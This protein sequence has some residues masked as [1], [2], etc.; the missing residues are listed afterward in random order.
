MAAPGR[1]FGAGGWVKPETVADLVVPQL[2]A[3]VTNT[4][5]LRG[6]QQA[7]HRLK[8]R[9]TGPSKEVVEAGM[10]PT[11][12]PHELFYT[13]MPRGILSAGSRAVW[14]FSL[15][16]VFGP[17]LFVGCATKGVAGGP[18][19]IA[20]GLAEGLVFGVLW[21][22]IGYGATASQ[23]LGGAFFSATSPYWVYGQRR[24]WHPVHREWA[25]P[26]TQ[27]DARLN[28]LPSDGEL[29]EE[30]MARMARRRDAPSGEVH[31]RGRELYAALGINE[32]ATQKEIKHAYLKASMHLHPD[33]NPSPSAKEEFDKVAKA[34]KVLSDPVARKKYDA[35][36]EDALKAG[37]QMDRR[38]TLRSIFGG[39]V[40]RDL[41]G[42]VR[43]SRVSRRLVDAVHYS[44]EESQILTTRAQERAATTL[45]TYLTDHP[46]EM[47]T[48]AAGKAAYERQVKVWENAVRKRF[49]AFVN[50]GVA[51]EMMYVIG[52]EYHEVLDEDAKSAAERVVRG[53][54]A[55]PA[56]AL[57]RVSPWLRIAYRGGK[58]ARDPAYVMETVWSLSAP[59]L[60]ATARYAAVKVILDES[61]DAAELRRRKVAL[62]D[63]A[64]LLVKAGK[65]WDGA[66]PA[67]MRTIQESAAA[68]LR[69][70]AQKRDNA[71]SK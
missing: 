47:P 58:A 5:G 40:L 4:P 46:G 36:G 27:Q 60:Q 19:G 68:D 24:L 17:L 71:T 7:T 25:R 26:T 10:G 2:E 56:R 67:V 22:G 37:G 55:W 16:T 66:S 48:D 57:Q 59:E 61:V 1:R 53:V 43:M 41:A 62:R 38:E 21:M 15:A 30:A 29:W 50:T 20:R 52:Q 39:D 64:R 18:V 31:A 51:K 65:P 54:A 9:T 3:F 34:Y 32:R 12:L 69:A 11:Q 70:K 8:S 49:H 14:N 28:A 63:L 6:L 35:G 13:K 33:R 42:D 44:V 23:L 45:L